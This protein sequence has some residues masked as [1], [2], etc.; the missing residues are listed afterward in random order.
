MRSA[1]ASGLAD[2]SCGPSQGEAA[3]RCGSLSEPQ[4][5]D[6][7]FKIRWAAGYTWAYIPVRAAACGEPHE[8]DLRDASCRPPLPGDCGPLGLFKADSSPRQAAA[9]RTGV[10]RAARDCSPPPGG[11]CGLPVAA[12]PNLP[13]SIFATVS[14]CGPLRPAGVIHNS[15]RVT[16]RTASIRGASPPTHVR[17]EQRTPV[18]TPGRCTPSPRSTPPSLRDRYTG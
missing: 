12:R 11:G 18:H 6:S 5:Q 3:A 17:A 14:G 4:I 15:S 13:A 1:R 8:A 2:A 9:E 16:A 10:Q 7:R